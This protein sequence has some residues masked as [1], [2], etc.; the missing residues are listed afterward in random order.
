[1][2]RFKNTL[3]LNDRYEGC[4][5]FEKPGSMVFSE[6]GWLSYNNESSRVDVD[7]SVGVVLTENYFV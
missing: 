1:M 3:L 4:H 2:T 7:E 5:V 6:I